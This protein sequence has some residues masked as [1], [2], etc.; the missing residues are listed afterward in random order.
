MSALQLAGAIVGLSAVLGASQQGQGPLSVCLSNDLIGKNVEST[1]GE[2]LGEIKDIVV[3]PGSAT[4]YAVVSFGG[5]MGVGDKLFAMPWSTLKH[6]DVDP[7]KGDG[8]QKLVLPI[9][10][11]RLKSAPGFDS[12]RWPSMA[13]AEWSRDVDTFYKDS[14]QSK[15]VA[16]VEAGARKSLL[17]WRLSEL[18][19]TEVR[20]P[21]GDDLGE[22]QGLAIDS[23]GRVNYAV[24]SVGGFLG[25]GERLVPV[26]WDALKLS[27]AGDDGDEKVITLSATKDQLAKAP[28]FKDGEDSRAAM[29]DPA[30]IARVH[31]HFSSPLY[32]KRD[33]GP[34]KPGSAR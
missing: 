2:E 9:E 21:D 13:N 19:G 25:M 15:S 30:W 4:S 27:M 20:T 1:R 8:E 17:T 18:E 6:V 12:S 28:E 23:N 22:I 16:P 34:A 26:P 14:A 31:E 32:W 10:K 11:D 3:H 7:G 33:A 24:L 29:C 5:W